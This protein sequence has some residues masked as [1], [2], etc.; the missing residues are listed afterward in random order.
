MKLNSR[1][2]N[3]SSVMSTSNVRLY[4]LLLAAHHACNFQ[5]VFRVRHSVVV[6]QLWKCN[7]GLQ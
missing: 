7:S 4:S 3:L 1:S 5:L 6:I 2:V